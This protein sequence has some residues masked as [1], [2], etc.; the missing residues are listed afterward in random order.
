MTILNNNGPVVDAFGGKV[1]TNCIIPRTS[2][3][4]AS[5]LRVP[6]KINDLVFLR[7]LIYVVS[8]ISVVRRQNPL[9]IFRHNLGDI[10]W[11]GKWSEWES[12]QGYQANLP[13][14]SVGTR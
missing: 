8:L 7:T 11:I 12:R 4:P 6:T 5:D 10:L 14:T 1:A 9:D 2:A 13:L 3:I